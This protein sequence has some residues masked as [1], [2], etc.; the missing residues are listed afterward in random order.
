MTLSAGADDLDA[1]VIA[2]GQSGIA[3]RRLD[4]L[5]SPLETMFFELTGAKGLAEAEAESILRSAASAP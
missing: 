5:M 3:V 4:L 1:F 2:L